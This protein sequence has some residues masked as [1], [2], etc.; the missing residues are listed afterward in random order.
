MIENRLKGTWP[1]NTVT[2][3]GKECDL[4]A[5]S[6][7]ARTQIEQLLSLG[8]DLAKMLVPLVELPANNSGQLRLRFLH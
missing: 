5:V 2:V 8:T 1:T 3:E 7:D 6:P 4:D